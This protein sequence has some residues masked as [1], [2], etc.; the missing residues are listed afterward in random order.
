MAVRFNKVFTK[1]FLR[2]V[3]VGVGFVGVALVTYLSKGNHFGFNVETL[4]GV[5]AQTAIAVSGVLQRYV[6]KTDP[7][8]GRAAAV[9]LGQVDHNLEPFTEPEPVVAPVGPNPVDTP[10]AG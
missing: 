3:Y 9:V 2:H 4:I 8:L 5:S 7:A 1:S 6:D 10:P